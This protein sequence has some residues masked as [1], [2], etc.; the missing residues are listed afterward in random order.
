MKNKFL[1][2]ILLGILIFSSVFFVFE[3]PVR[4][5]S[6][7]IQ[8]SNTDARVEETDPEKNFGNL[9][10]LKIKSKNSDNKRTF[11][12]FDLSSIP[13]NA[14]ISE[15]HLEL[16]L[17][18]APGNSRQYGIYAVLNSWDEGTINWDNQV[19]ATSTP[20]TIISYGGSGVPAKVWL[21]WDVTPDAIYFYNK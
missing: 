3:K 12:K 4:A 2:I 6:L 5:E 7:I 11:I 15:A 16:Y 21:S 1:N 18:D 13:A 8:P 10:E 9:V 20:T 17:T 19:N 14:L